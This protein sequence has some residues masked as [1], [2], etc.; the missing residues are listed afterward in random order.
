MW[1]SKCCIEGFR[2][3]GVWSTDSVIRS[4]YI[5]LNLVVLLRCI[6][7]YFS[8]SGFHGLVLLE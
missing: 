3:C 8:L 4:C 1:I 6:C 2:A 7:I 5:L